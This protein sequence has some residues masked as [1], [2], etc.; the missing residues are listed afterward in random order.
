MSINTFGRLLKYVAN[1]KNRNINVSVKGKHKI[2]RHL[3]QGMR[4]A[5]ARS[6]Y[7]N[8][9]S[10]FVSSPLFPWH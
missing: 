2:T 8:E 3:D 1:I 5:L 10:T 6:L 7:D 4:K 9:N